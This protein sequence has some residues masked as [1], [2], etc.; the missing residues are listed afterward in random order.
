MSFLIKDEELSEAYNII[1]D[2]VSNLMKKGL[3]SEPVYLKTKIKPY[4]G[5]MFIIMVFLIKVF[6]TLAY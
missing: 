3:D 2:R 1:W 6:I 5:E 4:A